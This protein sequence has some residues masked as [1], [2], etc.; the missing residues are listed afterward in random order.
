MTERA[1]RLALCEQAG[2]P[3]LREE[4]VKRFPPWSTPQTSLRGGN[5]SWEEKDTEEDLRLLFGARIIARR[6]APE[7]IRHR[8]GRPIWR[9][10][11][12]R[13]RR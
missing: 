5:T 12:F 8:K 4:G 9:L 11:S 1:R 3:F 2:G 6:R 7:S 13:A 10:R